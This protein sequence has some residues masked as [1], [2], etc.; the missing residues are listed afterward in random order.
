MVFRTFFSPKASNIFDQSPKLTKKVKKTSPEFWLW[1]KKI[2]FWQTKT[3]CSVVLIVFYVLRGTNWVKNDFVEN[4]SNFL[5]FWEIHGKDL[6]LSES[7]L[8]G[9]LRV[10]SKIKSNCPKN[11][12]GQNLFCKMYTFFIFFGCWA[13]TMAFQL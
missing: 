12:S 7:L 11:I 9:L 4:F 1:A 2:K 13:K 6:D 8:A 3:I 10:R 5:S